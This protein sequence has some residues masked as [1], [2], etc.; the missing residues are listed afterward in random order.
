MARGMQRAASGPVAASS[1]ALGVLA[2]CALVG[3][4]TIVGQWVG[5][6]APVLIPEALG[7][8]SGLPPLRVDPLGDTAIDQ[9]L[10]DGL[11]ALVLAAVVW[12]RC[13]W[14]RRPA[15]GA[16][17]A[18]V[19]GLVVATILRVVHVAV[20]AGHDLLSY[21]ATLAM[22]LVLAVVVGAL[23]GVPV[24]AVHLAVARRTA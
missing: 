11:A 20:V 6:I 21:G 3:S 2:A 15:L 14:T 24:A 12:W 23:L 9:W 16:W 8:P 19:A 17:F 22:A 4:W 1:A 5:R 10:A 7:V 13:R 18:T